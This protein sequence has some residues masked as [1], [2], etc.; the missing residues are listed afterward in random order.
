MLLIYGVPVF[1]GIIGSRYLS[2][3]ANFVLMMIIFE[4]D[5][6][7]LLGMSRPWAFLF[8]PYTIL[9]IVPALVGII[10]ERHLSK[11]GYDLQI[12]SRYFLIGK[13]ANTLLVIAV[14]WLNGVLLAYQGH[15]RFM[16]LSFLTGIF[17]SAGS[18]VPP[19]VFILIA[20]ISYRLRPYWRVV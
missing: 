18:V 4:F 10:G 19:L 2:R 11:C 1:A 8:E 7:L 5:I 16:P 14:F 9:F 20:I 12:G 6:A 15:G 13:I 3:V 17:V